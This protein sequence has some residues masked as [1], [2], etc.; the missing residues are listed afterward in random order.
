MHR[1]ATRGVAQGNLI[2]LFNLTSDLTFNLTW[3][4]ELS[5]ND[6]KPEDEQNVRPEGSKIKD[7]MATAS[8]STTLFRPQLPLS[9]PVAPTATR[10]SIPTSRSYRPP[11]AE[12]RTATYA[13]KCIFACP[14]R[15]LVAQLVR[16][17]P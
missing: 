3:I 16:A 14:C 7:K 12:S 11:V 13:D 8:L 9:K 2:I 6:L 1:T 5:R 15:G 17:H 4:D 10:S